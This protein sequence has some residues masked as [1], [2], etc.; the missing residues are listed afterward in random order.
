MRL[1]I[2][3]TK[4]DIK[5]IYKQYPYPMEFVEDKGKFIVVKN[6]GVEEIIFKKKITQMND[7]FITDKDFAKV[8]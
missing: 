8:K 1:V 3:D 5:N 7:I 6:K 2:I 4:K